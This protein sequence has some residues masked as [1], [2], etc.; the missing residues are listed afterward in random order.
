MVVTEED[1]WKDSHRYVGN[2]VTHPKHTVGWLPVRK[3][4]EEKFGIPVTKYY[5]YHAFN[6]FLE[7]IWFLVCQILKKF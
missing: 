6:C 4:A 5:A 7:I 2:L 1:T 3:T